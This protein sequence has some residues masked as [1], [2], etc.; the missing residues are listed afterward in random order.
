MSEIV[1]WL[2]GLAAFVAM[3]VGGF[4]AAKR[5]G[6][7][8]AKQEQAEEDRKAKETAQEVRDEVDQLDDDDLLDR[9]DRWVR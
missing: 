3:L 6:K 8:E 7:Q 5:K 9:A 4:F 2:G 1:S